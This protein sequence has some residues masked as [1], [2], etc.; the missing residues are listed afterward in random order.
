[1]EMS[2]I[3]SHRFAVTTWLHPEV[4]MV[5]MLAVVTNALMTR[6]LNSVLAAKCTR[7]ADC[8][9]IIPPGTFAA[10]SAWCPRLVAV[11][12]RAAS[13]EAMMRANTSAMEARSY[14]CAGRRVTTH[15]ARS[16]VIL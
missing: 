8:C 3:F 10:P 13:H 14:L 1:M 16:A 15:W 6:A 4:V 2:T 12:A 7:S 11:I 5:A 9:L